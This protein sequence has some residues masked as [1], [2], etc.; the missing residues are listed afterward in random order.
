MLLG[1][2]D[3]QYDLEIF[4]E[5]HNHTC[6]DIK[7]ESGGNLGDDFD[8]PPQLTLWRPLQGF[9]TPRY[10]FDFS[11]ADFGA[12]T[13]IVLPPG[14]VASATITG[15]QLKVCPD[16]AFVE[17]DPDGDTCDIIESPYGSEVLGVTDDRFWRVGLINSDE[18]IQNYYTVPNVTKL[19]FSRP[20]MSY[21]VNFYDYRV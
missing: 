4:W 3:N 17:Y 16:S 21:T 20:A 2:W 8:L 14:G 19:D 1:D 11:N 12:P 15:V 9:M 6:E 13:S 7:F 5:V 18:F 10:G